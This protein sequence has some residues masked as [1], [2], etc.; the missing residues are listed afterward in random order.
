MAASNWTVIYRSYSDDEL[1]AEIAKLKA[2]DS[3]FSE[4]GV[5]SKNA[6]RDLNRI[7]AKLTAATMEQASRRGGRPSRL[8]GRMD[9][10]N[11]R[12]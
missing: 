6:T 1:A 8:G 11:L 3:P 2:Q 5:G 4:Q 10:G 12:I 7:E 9:F